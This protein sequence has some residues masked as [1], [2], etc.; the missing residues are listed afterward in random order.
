MTNLNYINSSPIVYFNFLMI[1]CTYTILIPFCLDLLLFDLHFKHLSF[2]FFLSFL[3]FSFGFWDK[4]CYSS[5]IICFPGNGHLDRE[6]MKCLCRF[7]CISMMANGLNSFKMHRRHFLFSKTVGFHSTSFAPSLFSI[8]VLV[9]FN[10][11]GLLACLF[12]F[13]DHRYTLPRSI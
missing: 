8:F 12:F 6:Q 4:N 7:I 11:E 2:D 3:V 13:I 5:W 1:N 9:F 10:V